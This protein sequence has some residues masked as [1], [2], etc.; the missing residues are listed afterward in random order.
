MRW[1][2]YT[3]EDFQMKKFSVK[4]IVAIGIGAA[5]FFV[6]ASYVAIPTPIPNTKISVQYPVL[7][8]LSMLFGPAAGVLI[9]L[10]G[11][12]LTDLAG[13]WGVWWSWVAGSAFFGLVMGVVGRKIRLNEGEFGIKGAVV[14]NVAQ[15][16]THL[17]SWGLIAP[18]L[19][20][21][22]YNEPVEKIFLQG[23]VGSIGNI[24]STAIVGT[25]LCIA[26]VAARPKKGSLQ[27]ED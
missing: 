25:L 26:Y 23:A 27:K 1:G 16:I 22:I 20:I 9:G 14:F 17:I 4:T 2:K 6:L 24:V 13:G 8:V 10:I 18:G 5:L 12:F 15:I 7:A 11:H 3:K 21:L 19:D